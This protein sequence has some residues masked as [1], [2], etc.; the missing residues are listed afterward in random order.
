[1]NAT[2]TPWNLNSPDETLIL[3]PDRQ[4]V[5]TTLQDEED[6]QANYDRRAADAEYIVKWANN[7][8]RV[9]KALQKLL[10]IA[11]TPITDRQRDIFNE[12]RAALAEVAWTGRA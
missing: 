9:A 5:A 12:A 11:G 1:M 10:V 4:T 2:P 7:G 6:Y 8:P 3:G